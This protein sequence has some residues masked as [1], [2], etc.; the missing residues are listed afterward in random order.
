MSKMVNAPETL[1]H[2]DD[3]IF[4][5]ALSMFDVSHDRPDTNTLNGRVK[6]PETKVTFNNH[7]YYAAYQP[8]KKQ[9]F[10]C[11]HCFFDF[12]GQRT[13][14]YSH[15]KKCRLKCLA[16]NENSLLLDKKFKP[17]LVCQKQDRKIYA[18]YGI[19]KNLAK[20]LCYLS[21]F[22]VKSKSSSDVYADKFDYFLLYYKGDF[23][24][25]FSKELDEQ[26]KNFALSCLL[27][28]NF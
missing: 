8:T 25:Y 5:Q 10:V 28:E 21:R 15:I 24:G 4:N 11:H 6:N 20:R 27:I 14:Y 12:V 7:E 9:H 2:D 17:V 3:N 26:A 18:V 13:R 16:Q 22:F 23:V 19:E 1:Q